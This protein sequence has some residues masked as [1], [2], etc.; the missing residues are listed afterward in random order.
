MESLVIRVCS[1]NLQQVF[2]GGKGRYGTFRSV[3]QVVMG[4][5]ER[6]ERNRQDLYSML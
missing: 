6:E 5:K 1:D 3:I 4:I 2:S